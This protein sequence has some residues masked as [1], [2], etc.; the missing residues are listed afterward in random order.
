[1]PLFKGGIT[2]SLGG[3]VK[4]VFGGVTEVMNSSGGQILAVG[5]A[6]KLGGNEGGSLAREVQQQKNASKGGGEDTGN[7]KLTWW[8]KPLNFYKLATP[9]ILVDQYGNEVLNLA[10]KEGLSALNT[11]T[12]PAL[13]WAKIGT[14][15]GIGA[16][17]TWLF[18]PK[19]KRGAAKRKSSSSKKIDTNTPPINTPKNKPII[20][21]IINSH[22]PPPFVT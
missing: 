6:T 16:F 17:L 20:K 12:P 19:K 14:V 18:W 5:A 1:M 4:T 2:N 15:T 13:N 7:K 3:L 8:K 21:V 11:Q 22:I 10:N 9:E